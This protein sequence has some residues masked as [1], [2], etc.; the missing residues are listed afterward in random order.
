MKIPLLT[1]LLLGAASLS[2]ADFTGG[3]QLGVALPQRDMRKLTDS[4]SGA[5]VV[6]FGRWD[7]GAGHMIRARLDGAASIGK[8]SS[9][10]TPLGNVSTDGRVETTA[11]LNTLG[12]D[13]LHYFNGSPAKGFYAGAGLGY[14]STKLEL[15]LPQ[16]MG[17]LTLSRTSSGLAH[18]LF[19]GYQFSPHWSV[20]LGYRA[21]TFKNDF[22]ISG[23][24]GRFKYDMS[25][26]SLVAGYTF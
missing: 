15:E 14:G 17:G 24:T 19:A 2:A 25:V 12:A 23:N 7:L 10:N 16:T 18:G 21:S 8:P 13:Y 3:L 26:L 11:S 5:Q 9:I 4:S 6:L 22:T 20:E 1:T